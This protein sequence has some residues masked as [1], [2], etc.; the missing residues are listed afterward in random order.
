MKLSVISFLF[1]LVFILSS[2]EAQALLTTTSSAVHQVSPPTQAELATFLGRKL[3]AKE[4]IGLWIL[5]RKLKRAQRRHPNLFADFQGV[6]DTTKCSTIALKSG[7]KLQAHIIEISDSSVE[8][9]R[10]NYSD[11]LSLSKSDIEKITLYDGIKIYQN[12]TKYSYKKHKTIRKPSNNLGFVSIIFGFAALPLLFINIPLAIICAI[13][14]LFFGM[15][16]INAYYTQTKGFPVFGAIIG[17]LTIALASIR[18]KLA[19][20]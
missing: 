13:M 5:K 6:N 8:F 18:K 14:A 20:S 3:K 10:C 4:K 11:T 2:F 7:G 9:V 17:F 1:S 12:N 19:L 16:G 15:M